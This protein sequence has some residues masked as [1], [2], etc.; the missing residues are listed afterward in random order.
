[1]LADRCPGLPPGFLG[2]R[3]GGLVASS[4][5]REVPGAPLLLLDPLPGVG[6][7][8]VDAMKAGKAGGMVAGKQ[9]GE[10][11]APETDVWAGGFM[12]S[13]GYRLPR[14]LRD[15]FEGVSLVDCLGAEARRVLIVS[16]VPRHD[17]F[18]RAK[19][20][21]DLLGERTAAEVDLR[22]V[23]GK[24]SWWTERDWWEP[25]EEDPPTLEAI[26]A[27]VEWL[28]ARLAPEWTP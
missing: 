11:G 20:V 17:R 10:A 22:M 13:L 2:T 8:L 24:L 14:G 5:A 19:E 4:R 27:S 26:A 18:P 15:S 16:V 28:Q 7:F 1:V 6:P 25:D 23:E 3:L 21:A 9:A 12:D